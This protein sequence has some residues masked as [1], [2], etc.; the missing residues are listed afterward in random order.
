MFFKVPEYYSEYFCFKKFV[1]LFV[2]DGKGEVAEKDLYN[3]Y[4]ELKEKDV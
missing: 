1:F 2:L 3:E 4:E